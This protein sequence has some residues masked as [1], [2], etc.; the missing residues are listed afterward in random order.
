LCAPFSGADDDD[1]VA[2]QAVAQDV[3][4]AGEGEVQRGAE[5]VAYRAAAAGLVAEWV[6]LEVDTAG[7]SGAVSSTRWLA[8][9]L[10]GSSRLSRSSD[11]R[12]ILGAK[13]PF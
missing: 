7:V 4:A 9:V 2:F 8:P 5:A 11:Q 13:W 3:G 1:A 12:P 10:R 6:G